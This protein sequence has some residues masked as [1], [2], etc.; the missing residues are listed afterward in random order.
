MTNGSSAPPDVTQAGPIIGPGYNYATV[1]DKISAI[2]LTQAP[3]E[4]VDSRICRAHF[5]W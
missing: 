4:M 2:V 3:A 1:T 5:S